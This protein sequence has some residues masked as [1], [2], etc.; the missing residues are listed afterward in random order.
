MP[1]PEPFK[2]PLA[3]DPEAMQGEACNRSPA[4]RQNG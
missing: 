4:N 1:I 2:L 3:H